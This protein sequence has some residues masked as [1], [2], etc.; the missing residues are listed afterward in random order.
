MERL[1]CN[2]DSHVVD[3]GCGQGRLAIGLLREVGALNYVG[4]DVSKTSIDWCKKHI[5]RCHPSF[6]FFHLDVENERYN[7]TG[8]SIPNDF[9]FPLM[10]SRVDV[11]YL[12][13]VF[14]N[15]RPEHMRIYLSDISRIMRMGGSVFLTAFVEKGVPAVSINPSDYVPFEYGGPL[16]V[17]RYEEEH[18]FSAFRERGLIVHDFQHH[19]G[20]YNQSEIYLKRVGHVDPVPA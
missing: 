8:K 10:D 5:Q 17:V 20:M 7:P 19:K 6:R 16:H 3:I 1:E 9:R 4:F 18:L 15:M 2:K 13:S 11:A 12:W 14:T